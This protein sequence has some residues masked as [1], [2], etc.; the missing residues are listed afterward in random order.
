[1]AQPW[2]SSGR[3]TKAPDGSGR[4]PACGQGC[5]LGAEPAWEP[6]PALSRQPYPSLSRMGCCTLLGSLLPEDEIKSKN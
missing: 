4:P 6:H 2:G 5:P 3:R 1:M